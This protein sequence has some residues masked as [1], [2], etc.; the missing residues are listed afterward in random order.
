MP[1]TTT[2]VMKEIKD[3]TQKKGVPCSWIRRANND[4]GA[5]LGKREL[6]ST[7]DFSCCDSRA[8]P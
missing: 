8:F 6:T 4:K 3:L 5:G 1:N 2:K 7:R